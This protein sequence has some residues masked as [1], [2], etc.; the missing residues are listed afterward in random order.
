[1]K[2]WILIAAMSLAQSRSD[3]AVTGRWQWRGTYGWQRIEMNLKGEGT[4]LTGT[5]RMGPGAEEPKSTEDLWEYFFDPVDFK[6]SDGTVAGNRISFEQD[7]TRTAS[8]RQPFRGVSQPTRYLYKGVVEGDQIVMAREVVPD[9]K[10]PWSQGNQ[11][12]E[13]VLQRVK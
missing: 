4:R 11:R 9:K 3:E 6:I 8:G 13:F 7:V 12:I 5:I 2:L 1:M 10:D